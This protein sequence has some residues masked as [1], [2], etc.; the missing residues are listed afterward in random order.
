[1]FIMSK[2]GVLTP[3]YV[4][5]LV[6]F[7]SIIIYFLCNNAQWYFCALIVHV[8]LHLCD[9]DLCQQYCLLVKCL[10][11]YEPDIR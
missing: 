7:R 10:W 5:G 3:V 8:Q 2:R 11:S 4:E 6:S 1:M 9:V